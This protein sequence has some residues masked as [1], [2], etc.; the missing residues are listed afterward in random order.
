MDWKVSMGWLV[1]YIME[2]IS[3]AH[4]FFILEESAITHT[5]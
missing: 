5:Y 4:P 1:E 3:P 2:N